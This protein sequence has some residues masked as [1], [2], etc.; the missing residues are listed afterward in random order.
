MPILLSGTSSL[1]TRRARTLTLSGANTYSG[2]TTINSA[3]NLTGSIATG[4][5]NIAGG[6]S[7]TV[8]TGAVIN[9]SNA[10]NGQFNVGS[11]A[12]GNAILN[13]N[14]GTINAGKNTNPSFV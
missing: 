8:N 6:G 4:A 14:G 11:S 7:L 13:I 12:G 10:N 2:V 3:V 9:P 1:T 5:V